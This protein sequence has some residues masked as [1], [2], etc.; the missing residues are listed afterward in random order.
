MSQRRKEIDEIRIK[1]SFTHPY[2]V[3]TMHFEDYRFYFCCSNFMD[4]DITSIA[5]IGVIFMYRNS[6]MDEK[7]FDNDDKQK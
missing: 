7:V 1:F 5:T 6:A 3:E 4:F 2:V